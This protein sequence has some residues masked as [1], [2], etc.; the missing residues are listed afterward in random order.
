MLHVVTMEADKQL[1]VG[2]VLLASAFISYVG[3][4]TKTFRDKLMTQIFTPF[5]QEKLIKAVGEN[6]SIPL[7][8]AADPVKVLTV[9]YFFKAT[10]IN[11]VLYYCMYYKIVY[12]TYSSILCLSNVLC[13]LLDG[14][15]CC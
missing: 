13:I 3:P 10:S 1:L 12:N 7:S 8:P 2:D 6:G 15:R 9:R 5:L 4:F 14:C 11:I